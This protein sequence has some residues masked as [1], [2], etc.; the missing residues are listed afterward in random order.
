MESQAE[1]Q[2]HFES[3]NAFF[4]R[5]QYVEA[6]NEYE[7]ATEIDSNH[8]GAYNKWGLVLYNQKRYEEAIKKCEEAINVDSNYF[9]YSLAHHNI[10]HVLWK[11]GKYKKAGEKWRKACDVF[12]A[13]KKAR[14]ANDAEHFAFYGG[15]LLTVFDNFKKAEEILGEGLEIDPKHIG[16]LTDLGYYVLLTFGSLIFMIAGFYLPNLLKLKFGTIEL[17]KG[18]AAQ[19]TPSGGLDISK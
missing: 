16:I 12:S 4:G 6:C 11:Q 14:A 15:V 1:A 9:V 2:R 8:V 18:P 5:G 17:E 13:T 10:A 19:I 7:N 3:G